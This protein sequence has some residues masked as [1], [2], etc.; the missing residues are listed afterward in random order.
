MA[1]F[2]FYQKEVTFVKERVSDYGPFNTGDRLSF[3]TTGDGGWGDPK[4]RDR[5]M[6][7][8][9]LRNRLITLAQAKEWYGYAG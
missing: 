8:D 3:Q 1:A 6:I 9:D 4:K 2:Q 5:K 7:E